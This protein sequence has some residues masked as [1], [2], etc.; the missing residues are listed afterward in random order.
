MIYFLSISNVV[1]RFCWSRTVKGICRKLIFLPWPAIE[2]IMM[3]HPH[4]SLCNKIWLQYEDYKILCQYI[5]FLQITKPNSIS[6]S[7]FFYCQIPKNSPSLKR[8]FYRHALYLPYNGSVINSLKV[9]VVKLPLN[10]VKC[11]IMT[12]KWV[13]KNK[14][15][16][17]QNVR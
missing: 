5:M 14:S 12:E 3:Q 11:L 13:I 17:H 4:Y 7:W 16:L 6:P 10:R 8:Y 15:C 9:K 2:R 1:F